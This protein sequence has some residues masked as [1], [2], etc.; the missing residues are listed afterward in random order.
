MIEAVTTSPLFGIVL[1]IGIMMSVWANDS[2]AYLVGSRFV[3]QCGKNGDGPRRTELGQSFDRRKD[4]RRR[5][6]T[7]LRVQ[8]A[9]EPPHP[10]PYLFFYH[11]SGILSDNFH[12]FRIVITQ[13]IPIFVALV[14][15]P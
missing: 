10:F 2:F 12:P 15:N 4:R 14:R 7:L 13:T 6:Q 3:G 11:V 1:C 5:P 8:C 9:V